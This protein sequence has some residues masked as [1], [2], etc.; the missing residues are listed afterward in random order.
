MA[1]MGLGR[2][3]LEIEPCSYGYSRLTFRGPAANTSKPY[4]AFLGASETVGPFLK[5][6]FPQ[7]VAEQL[8][9]GCANLGVK[10]AGPDVFLNDPDI[11]RVAKGAR[12][13][14]IEIMGAANLSN[15]F[16]KVHPSRNDRFICAHDELYARAPGLDLVDVHFTGHLLKEIKSTASQVLPEVIT[17]LQACWVERMQAL[18]AAVE[19]P[20]HLVRFVPPDKGDQETGYVET[21]MVT[22]LARNVASITRVTPSLEARANGTSEMFFA[23]REAAIALHMH[24]AATHR[25]AADQICLAIDAD[26]KKAR[27]G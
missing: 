1:D 18:I 26:I 19:A 5:R 13:V 14:V 23:P 16:Y 21:M 8:N 24:S 6:P 12:A 9:M 22:A 15:A 17:E 27:A 7:L 25:E 2:A 4:I 11:L 20:V 10:N 3:L